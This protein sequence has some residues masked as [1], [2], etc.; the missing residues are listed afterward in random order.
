MDCVTLLQVDADIAIIATIAKRLRLYSF[1][2]A[3]KV[4]NERVMKQA[5]LL[6]LQVYVGL[7]ASSPDSFET[8]VGNLPGLLA[9]SS[10]VVAALLVGNEDL[11]SERITVDTLAGYVSVV[12]E[13]AEPYGIPVSIADAPVTWMREDVVANVLPLVDFIGAQIHPW[14][15]NRP[16]DCSDDPRP[17]CVSAASYTAKT[18]M[19]LSRAHNKTVVITETGWP[20]RGESCCR[21]SDG[22]SFRAVSSEHNANVYVN[23]LD[24]AIAAYDPADVAGYM[25]YNTFDSAWM[26]K[27]NPDCG[28]EKCEVLSGCGPNNTCT[29]KFNWGLYTTSRNDD[30]RTAKPGIDFSGI[31]G[32]LVLPSDKG[33]SEF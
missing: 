11:L 18:A 33:F 31:T 14:W 16:V 32:G 2:T 30:S 15:A 26:R 3:C 23:G 19:N 29:Y 12:K 8:E 6:G 9:R 7:S 5:A 22:R 10:A 28:V 21:G 27:G 4:Q 17:V 1:A 24:R 25:Y 13:I 20:T